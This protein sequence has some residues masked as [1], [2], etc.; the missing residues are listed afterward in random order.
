MTLVAYGLSDWLYGKASFMYGQS[1]LTSV[2]W[3][4]KWELVTVIQ[5]KDPIHY[6]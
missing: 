1:D 2:V 5:N 3:D 6:H 4:W